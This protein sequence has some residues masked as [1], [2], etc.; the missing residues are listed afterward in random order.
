MYDDVVALLQGESIT[1]TLPSKAYLD[2][3]APDDVGTLVGRMDKDI[4]LD[5]G[6]G[7]GRSDGTSEG[8]NNGGAIPYT[9]RAPQSFLAAC[10]RPIRELLRRVY[11]LADRKCS[12]DGDHNDY[13][14]G[15]HY[16]HGIQW[17]TQSSESASWSALDSFS[18]L[19]AWEDS[20]PRDISKPSDALLRAA[21]VL[22]WWRYKNLAAAHE[23]ASTIAS[24]RRYRLKKNKREN[25]HP[26]MSAFSDDE[27]LG[28]DSFAHGNHDDDEF[29][30]SEDGEEP[31]QSFDSIVRQ[32]R[33]RFL[34]KKTVSNKGDSYLVPRPIEERLALAL[35]YHMNSWES[36]S[37]KSSRRSEPAA[38]PWTIATDHLLFLAKLFRE[39]EKS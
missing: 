9:Y 5:G 37:S 39:P 26:A 15:H 31:I 17:D 29:E 12:H 21:K 25:T 10:N 27:G 7:D 11:P 8:N 32:A 19:S 24:I 36:F 14:N 4:E 28:V 18:T 22:P 38:F 20:N 35:A 13:G 33:E 34:Y 23:K 2:R 3:F 16:N 6:S 1:L 30:K